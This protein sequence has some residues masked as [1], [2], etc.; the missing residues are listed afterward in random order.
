MDEDAQVE[1]AKRATAD[2][3]PISPGEWQG[4]VKEEDAVAPAQFKRSRCFLEN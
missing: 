4:I 1:A 3:L 2:P